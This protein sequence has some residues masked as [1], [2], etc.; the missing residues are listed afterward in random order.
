[1]RIGLYIS[2][3]S[4]GSPVPIGTIV[5]RFERA[6]AEGFH[7]AW[8]GQMLDYDALTLL[9]VA[10]RATQRIELGSWVIPAPLHHPGVLAQQALTV[11]AASG[12]RLVLGIGAGHAEVVEKR[13]GVSA[14]KP[15]RQMR[16][17]MAALRPLLAGEKTEHAGERFRISLALGAPAG[18]PP[19]VLLAALGPA[20]LRLAGEAADGAAIWLGSP[21]FLEERAIPRLRE[22]ARSAGR[23]APR[24][25][26]G[27]P[28]AVT[29]DPA[30]AR[31]GA[32]RL[33]G[34]SS[35]L[36]A[37]RRVLA[38]GGLAA[39]ADA[40]ISGDEQAVTSALDQLA[41]LGVTDFTAVLFD[42]P[43][44]PDAPVRTRALLAARA[45][46]GA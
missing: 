27:F 9:A 18:A 2:A 21:R 19:P 34:R 43:G 17:Y 11:Q 41:S 42:V 14:A 25:A 33:I 30:A 24:I 4:A 28:I 44:D 46:S 16:E 37:Y 1:V 31:E 12:G 7:T 29:R 15:A 23:P 10:A 8:A 5:A 32:E 39:P 13:F 22:A 3:L 38:R 45:R 36:P 20:M 40:A 26:C 6:E 35:R